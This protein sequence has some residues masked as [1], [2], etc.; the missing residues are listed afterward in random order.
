MLHGDDYAKKFGGETGD[1]PDW[2]LLSITGYDADVN[3][4]GTVDFYLAD[5]Q[6]EDNSQDYIID[7]WTWVNLSSL[8]EVTA[9]EFN[10][11]SSDNDPVWGMNTPAYFAMDSVGIVPEPSTMVL[12]V[13]GA[14]AWVFWWRRRI[15]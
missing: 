3:P 2:F 7:Q 1:D 10:L 15:G 8:G 13:C 11:S 9:L 6:F 4:S 12:I 14:L 5:Y